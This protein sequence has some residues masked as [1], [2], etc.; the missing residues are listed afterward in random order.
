MR[1][2]TKNIKELVENIRTITRRQHHPETILPISKTKIPITNQ[3]TINRLEISIQ[4]QIRLPLKKH[5][6][7]RTHPIIQT[8]IS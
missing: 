1:E 6:I 7:Y 8:N 4:I 5:P 3:N 2:S